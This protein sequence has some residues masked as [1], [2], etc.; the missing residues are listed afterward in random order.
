MRVSAAG[1]LCLT[2]LLPED[3]V[4][5][6]GFQIASG[7]DDMAVGD[8]FLRLHQGLDAIGAEYAVGGVRLNGAGRDRPPGGVVV[9]D[10]VGSDRRGT[11]DEPGGTGRDEVP[12]PL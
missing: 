5:G 12:L 8:Q 4:G 1:Q 3:R 9:C 6:A 7:D 10:L 11:L 2:G